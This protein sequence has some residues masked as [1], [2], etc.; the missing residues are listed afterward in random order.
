MRAVRIWPDRSDAY[1][2]YLEQAA[3]GREDHPYRQ[4]VYRLTRISRDTLASD[5]YQL[6]QPERWVGCWQ[7]PDSFAGLTPDSLTSRTGCTVLLK[8]QTQH[9]F[10]G[11][12]SGRE[13]RNDFAGAVYATAE[14]KVTP[15]ALISWD[16]G[17]NAGDEQ[18]WGATVGP[19][20]F[21]R[22]SAATVVPETAREELLATDRRFSRLSIAEGAQV[23]F[24]QFMA[25]EAIVYRD[26][27]APFVGREAILSLFPPTATGRLSWEPYFAA[28]GEGGNLGY[29]LGRYTYTASD[30]SGEGQT[31]HGYYVTIWRR[32]EDGSWKYVFDSGVQAPEVSDTSAAE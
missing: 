5:I 8:R 17:F 12:T 2:L 24:D 23:A 16:R 1:W 18:V 22:I 27:A 4:R 25:E 10:T 15:A 29:T 9:L 3:A 13:C 32:Q 19:Y 21:S 28:A 14:V 11:S 20:V 26:G 6:P 7:T 31:S 30:A